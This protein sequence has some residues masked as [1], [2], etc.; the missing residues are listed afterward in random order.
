MKR[1]RL[2]N[3]LSGSTRFETRVSNFQ[4][5]TPASLYL[6]D[7]I[8]GLE[9]VLG[10]DFVMA[11]TE[12]G[13]ED[14]DLHVNSPGGDVFE[15]ISILNHLRNYPGTVTAYVDG[16]AASA[17]SFILAGADNVVMQQNSMLMIHDAWGLCMGNSQDMRTTA[18]LLDKTSDN[19]ASIYASVTDKPAEHWREQMRQEVWYTADEAVSAGLA[20]RVATKTTKEEDSPVYELLGAKNKLPAKTGE[21]TETFDFDWNPAE[22]L[23][24]FEEATR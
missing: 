8:G 18:D 13:G 23:R 16:I 5:K 12:L 14:F 22:V 6:Y 20:G 21:E 4:T 19:I 15:G 24:A 17:A 2:F 11:L 7:E 1:R 9:G 10:T 3:L